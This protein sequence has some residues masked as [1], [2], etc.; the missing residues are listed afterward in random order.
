M[1][2][3]RIMQMGFV[4]LL[5]CAAADAGAG[6]QGVERTTDGSA[7]ATPIPYTESFVVDKDELVPTGRNPFF[8]LEPG[9]RLVLEGKDGQDAV[10][11]IITVLDETRTVDGVQTRTVEERE[12]ENGELI[13]ISRNYFA[14]SSRTNDVYYFGEEVDIYKDGKIV[15]HEGAWMSGEKG[16]RFGLLMPGSPLLGA[17]YHQEIA[18]GVAMDRALV[19]S[20]G[21]TIQT[22]AGR[23]EGCLRTMEDTPLEENSEEKKSYAPWIGL[24][25]EEN[26]RLVSYGR[27]GR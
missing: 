5:G 13:E 22:P 7:Q 25:Q 24:I 10:Q 3:L 23:F 15:R 2:T 11:L 4:A 8:I 14:I 19:L 1:L 6:T 21:E 18:P 16:A 17:K 12:S 26:L 9:Y 27:A 20:L